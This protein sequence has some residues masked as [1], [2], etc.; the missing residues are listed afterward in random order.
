MMTLQNSPIWVCLEHAGTKFE[1]VV[2]L[3]DKRH[4]LFSCVE[5]FAV[6]RWPVI[7]T[8]PPSV[9]KPLPPNFKN[10]RPWT[11]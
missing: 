6:N 10:Y 7:T 8:A 4:A 5:C 3:E 9:T 1:A 2:N 11:T